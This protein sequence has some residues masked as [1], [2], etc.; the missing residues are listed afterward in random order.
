MITIIIA[1][2]VVVAAIVAAAWLSADADG[3][4]MECANDALT[5]ATGVAFHCAKFSIRLVAVPLLAASCG[6]Y[7]VYYRN[8]YEFRAD[9]MDNI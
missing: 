3:E 5:N 7:I 6:D 8:L 4:R 1:I 9:F 2:A